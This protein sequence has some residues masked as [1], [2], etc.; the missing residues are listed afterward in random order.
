MRDV[1]EVMT[2]TAISLN[3]AAR[4]AGN[5]IA[6]RLLAYAVDAAH[7]ELVAA[8]AP[9]AAEQVASACLRLANWPGHMSAVTCPLGGHLSAPETS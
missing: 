7:A 2:F 8:G 3:L 4:A 5:P 6:L 9:E 1:R